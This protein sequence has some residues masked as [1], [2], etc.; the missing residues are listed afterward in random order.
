MPSPRANEL[1]RANEL[2]PRS[3]LDTDVTYVGQNPTRHWTGQWPNDTRPFTA[4]AMLEVKKFAAAFENIQNAAGDVYNL[5]AE[6]GDVRI[7]E[8]YKANVV[9]C[10]ESSTILISGVRKQDWLHRERGLQS[11]C[12]GRSAALQLLRV[13]CLTLTVT[14][15]PT[16]PAHLNTFYK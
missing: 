7:R 2:K 12:C 8:D 3:F 11:E 9:V 4:E 15:I 14:L 10:S 13:T 16:V 5:L 1:N 6:A